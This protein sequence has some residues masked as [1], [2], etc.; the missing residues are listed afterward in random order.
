MKKTRAFFALLLTVLLTFSVCVM[1]A[2]AKG[3]NPSPDFI[4][5]DVTQN[6]K[7]NLYDAVYLFLANIGII[8]LN[9]AQKLAADVNADCKANGADRKLIIKYARKAIAAFPVEEMLWP[10]G[11]PIETDYDDNGNPQI[12]FFSRFHNTPVDALKATVSGSGMIAANA[13][14]L[15]GNFSLGFSQKDVYIDVAPTSL[16]QDHANSK[17]L[18]WVLRNGNVRCRFLQKDGELYAVLPSMHMYLEI[19]DEDDIP[20][21]QLD[22]ME[23]YLNMLDGYKSW[24]NDYLIGTM[25]SGKAAQF[26][27]G[28]S[29][30]QVGNAQY[31]CEKY[32]AYRAFFTGNG[33]LRHIEVTTDAGNTMITIRSVRADVDA[34]QFEIPASCKKISVEEFMRLIEAAK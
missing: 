14:T 6:G 27:E 15:N 2:N 34:E 31:V 3:Q 12:L 28:S 33:T 23:A 10:E 11:T 26:Y 32:G 21:D 4:Y 8:H 29:I 19:P 7:I 9:D 16:Q 20:E 5:G 18:N 22:A 30:V 13:L 25:L 17:L 24:I 1:P